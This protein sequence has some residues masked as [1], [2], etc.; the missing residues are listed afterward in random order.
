MTPEEQ[1][2]VERLT[3]WLKGEPQDVDRFKTDLRTL[4]QLA[5]RGGEPDD[6]PLIIALA[7]IR[8]ITGVG[9]VPMLTELPDAVAKAWGERADLRTLLQLAERG[10]AVERALSKRSFILSGPHLS[11][12]TLTLGFADRDDVNAAHS[13]LAAVR[14]Q[15]GK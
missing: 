11:G 15:G 13:A 7:R 6:G 2:A 4:L 1:E 14:D 12:W 9:V 3:A 8:E 10:A 5:E